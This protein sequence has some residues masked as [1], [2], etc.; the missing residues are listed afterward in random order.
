VSSWLL[1]SS[2]SATR[3]RRR[4]PQRAGRVSIGDCRRRHD[5]TRPVSADQFGVFAERSTAHTGRLCVAVPTRL[6]QCGLRPVC[7]KA[8]CEPFVLC[9]DGGLR[10]G[11]RA[12][13]ARQPAHLWSPQLCGRRIRRATEADSK[14]PCLR[15]HGGLDDDDAEKG[16]GPTGSSPSMRACGSSPPPDL[17]LPL[18]SFATTGVSVF[19]DRSAPPASPRRSPRT[20]AGASTHPA[21]TLELHPQFLNSSTDRRRHPLR[22]LPQPLLTALG[23]R[24]RGVSVTPASAPIGGCGRST[25]VVSYLRSWRHLYGR[26][27]V[28]RSRPRL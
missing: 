18:R 15:Q 10:D 7:H 1:S 22:R 5:Q 14:R 26:R 19:C 13:P 3:A 20:A 17:R 21:S 12:A 2:A 27:R 8:D 4:P 24:P 16:S 9:I 11:P 28:A 23:L 25:T 6:S